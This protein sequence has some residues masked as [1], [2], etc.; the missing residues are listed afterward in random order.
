MVLTGSEI[1]VA[2]TF[3]IPIQ[4]LVLTFPQQKLAQV[5]SE[6]NSHIYWLRFWLRVTVGE[7]D[8]VGWQLADAEQRQRTHSS[9]LAYT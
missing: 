1:L 6:V 8:T 9:L 3:A 7:T 4:R 2:T 5:W